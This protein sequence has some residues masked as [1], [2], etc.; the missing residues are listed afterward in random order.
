MKRISVSKYNLVNSLWEAFLAYIIFS[1][2]F[3]NS[4]F[5]K[6]FDRIFSKTFDSF[7]AS[8]AVSVWIF[9][10]FLFLFPFIVLAFFL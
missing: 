5:F 10:Y 6:N 8:L 9:P 4:G 3:A 1:Y 7:L 2:I